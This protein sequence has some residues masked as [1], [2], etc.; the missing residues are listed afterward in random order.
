MSSKDKY[1]NTRYLKILASIL[2]SMY[3]LSYASGPKNLDKWNLIDDVNLIIHEAGHSIF[4]FFGEFIHVFG[5][6]FF[7]VTFPLVFVIYFIFWRREYLSA[8]IL[9][10][11]VGQNIL[12]VAVYMGD[13]IVLQ[14]PLL[15]GDGVI[16]DWN[17]LLNSLNI[18]KYTNIL[19]TITYDI[20]FF[21]I[22]IAAVSS[23]YFSWYNVGH[24][25][26]NQYN[27]SNP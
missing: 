10:F 17:Y 7:Q 5:G 3:F 27:Q 15:G 26:T 22:I 13:S 8:S 23:L 11:W 12:D 18:L 4:M 14:L 20:G 9:L 19:S 25:Y 16:H 21:V 2:I 6:S 1:L 24:E